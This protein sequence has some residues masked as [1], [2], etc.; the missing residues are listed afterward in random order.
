[1]NQSFRNRSGNYWFDPSIFQQVPSTASVGNY[2]TFGRNALR[3]PHQFNVNVTVSKVVPVRET[4]KLEYRADFFNMLNNA[5]FSTPS[6]TITSTQFGQ[7]SGTASPR[8]IQ[9]ALRLQF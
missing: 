6:T 8:I 7:I 3:G 9:M 4:L 5:Q 1:V 2:G